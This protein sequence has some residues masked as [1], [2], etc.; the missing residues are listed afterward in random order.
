M[1]G[2]LLDVGT[3][4]RRECKKKGEGQ[5]TKEGLLNKS[6]GACLHSEKCQSLK[7]SVPHEGSEGGR[8]FT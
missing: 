1:R 4:K 8:T 6:G 7:I 5:K 2:E 3:S